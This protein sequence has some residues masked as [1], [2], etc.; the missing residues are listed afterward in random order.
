MSTLTLNNILAFV[1]RQADRVLGRFFEGGEMHPIAVEKKLC[2]AIDGGARVFLRK[3]Y[4]PNR[5]RVS[6]HPADL[7]KYKK[8]Y[9][10]F[11]AEL[12]TTA[13]EHI[14]NNVSLAEN[15]D[16]TITITVR[17]DPTIQKGE[18]LCNAELV[19]GVWDNEVDREAGL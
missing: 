4:A 16:E 8:Y 2:R 17:E 9:D 15:V 11:I 13:E 7:E 1:E 19:S 12:Q 10:I 14:R 3:V 6:L 5:I 18:V